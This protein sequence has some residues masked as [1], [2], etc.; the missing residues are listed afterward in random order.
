MTEMQND[1][2]SKIAGVTG[3]EDIPRLPKSEYVPGARIP[4]ASE[5]GE[6]EVGARQFGPSSYR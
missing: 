3:R 6:A 2:A 1:V 4:G 5:A